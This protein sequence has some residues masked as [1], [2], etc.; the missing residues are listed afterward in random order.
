[1]FQIKVH[2][3]IRRSLD[4]HDLVQVEAAIYAAQMFAA[5]SKL[6]AIFMCSKISDMIRGQ[7][8]PASMKLQLIPI[9][10]YMYHDISTASMASEL[11]ME[12]LES[13]PA[14]DFVRTTLSTSTT[15]ASAA[16]IHVP[17]QV[18]LLLKY[19]REDP[20]LTIKMHALQLL[21]A[22]ANKGAHLWP[23]GALEQLIGMRL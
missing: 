23:Q 17:A 11:C 9:L 5:Q 7:A 16:L 1:M 14:V 3:S 21:L 12:L 20:R 2:H 13:Y 6:F 19:L 4:C 18:T 22:L 10:Q 8:T 15:L